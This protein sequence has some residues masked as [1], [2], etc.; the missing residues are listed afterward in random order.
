MSDNGWKYMDED[1]EWHYFMHGM[2]LCHEWMTIIPSDK[3]HKEEDE[4]NCKECVD[5]LSKK[6]RKRTII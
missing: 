1:K 2:S 3:G 4:E 6:Q 5:I